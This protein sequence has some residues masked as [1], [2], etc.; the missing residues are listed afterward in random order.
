M[1]PNKFL[2]IADLHLIENLHLKTAEK[3]LHHYKIKGFIEHDYNRITKLV[4]DILIIFKD[5]LFVTP[6]DSRK[7]K[8]KYGYSRA[9]F[10]AKHLL[11]H[12]EDLQEF[13]DRSFK[14]TKSTQ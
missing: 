8:R 5:D 6:S 14:A 3:N 11:E 2:H 10:S 9:V 13:V 12:K 1:N 7:M 4:N